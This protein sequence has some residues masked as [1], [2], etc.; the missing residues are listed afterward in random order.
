MK[1]LLFILFCLATATVINAQNG[2][3][4][5]LSEPVVCPP[6]PQPIV[7]Q[8]VTIN[9]VII[10]QQFIRELNG[11]EYRIVIEE[12]PVNPARNSVFIYSY[13]TISDGI[14]PVGFLRFALAPR[15]EDFRV[16]PSD[17][18]GKMV[19]LYNFNGETKK[20]EFK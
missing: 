13:K 8:N 17:T 12:H 5:V 16:M 1:K 15:F 14:Q 10:E 3:R 19:I 6:Q 2:K 18:P 7:T 20:I 4:T 11:T 9:E